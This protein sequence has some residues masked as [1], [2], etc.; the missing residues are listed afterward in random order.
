[1]IPYSRPKRSDLYTPPRV[2]CFK[3]IPF[4]AAH[5]YIAH[6]WQYS[7]PPPP[8]LG[9]TEQPSS[10]KNFIEGAFCYSYIIL[11]LGENFVTAFGVDS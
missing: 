7:P 5:T 2:N 11:V 6:I 8:P 10:M 9:S 1:M 3:T 4:T